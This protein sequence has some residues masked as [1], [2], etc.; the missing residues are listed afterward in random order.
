M[1]TPIT[2]FSTTWC[3]HC[4]RLQRQLDAAGIA[5]E[6]VDLDEHPRHGERIRR[7]TGGNRTVPSVDIEGHLLVNPTVNQ[8]ARRL[9]EP[10]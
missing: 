2:L 10:N 8:I 1:S 9:E 4:H 6:V 3:G 5:Y 7:A